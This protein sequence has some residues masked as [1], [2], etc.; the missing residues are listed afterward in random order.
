MEE[1]TAMGMGI[2]TGMPMVWPVS[3][4]AEIMKEMCMVAWK[5][6]ADVD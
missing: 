3:K 1:L 5:G 6:G 2:L 4:R